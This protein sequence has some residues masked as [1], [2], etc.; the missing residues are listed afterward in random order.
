MRTSEKGL[1]QTPTRQHIPPVQAN[2]N[3]EVKDSYQTR[4][5]MSLKDLIVILKEWI[6]YLKSKWIIFVIVGLLGGIGGLSYAYLKKPL[7][8]AE[9]TFVLEDEKSGGMGS[10]AGLAGQLGINMGL[11]G[12]QGVFEGENLLALMRS[13]LM[14]E[15]TLMSVVTV[16]GKTQTLAEMYIDVNHLWKG[17][18]ENNST[19]KN[20]K[21][22]QG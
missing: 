2:F 5:E 19:L 13:R 3:T 15:K 6:N 4:D 7:Y 1:S 12:G 10:Y 18:I 14:I 17:W 8:T 16:N 20:H 22:Q 11:S 21:H 9:T